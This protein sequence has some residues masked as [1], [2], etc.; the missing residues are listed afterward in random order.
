MQVGVW[1]GKGDLRA[2]LDG[3]E[4]VRAP[5]IHTPCR[6]VKAARPA[7]GMSTCV[8]RRH[9]LP[10]IFGCPACSDRGPPLGSN[11]Q[12]A[13]LSKRLRTLKSA[14]FCT[15]RT[16]V[17]RMCFLFKI[18][19]P[20]AWLVGPVCLLQVGTMAGVLYAGVPSSDAVKMWVKV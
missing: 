14:R 17:R 1:A 15:P 18:L 13:L 7:H 16:G 8:P 20:L 3:Q 10:R 5:R 2:S 19:L 4:R 12:Q 6:A 11:L 9:A